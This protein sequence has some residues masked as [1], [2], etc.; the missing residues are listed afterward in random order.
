MNKDRA[1]ESMKAFYGDD[2]DRI[3]HTLRVLDFTERICEGEGVTDPFQRE[4]I[5]M[6]AIF[7]DV[8]IP[9]ALRK[10]GT[11]A[12]PFQEREG[13]PVARRLLIEIGTRPDV[14]ERVCHI[15]GHHHTREAVDGLDFQ[16]FWESDALVNIPRDLAR[17][18]AKGQA[19]AELP[20]EKRRELIDTYFTTATG[21][22]LIMG[23]I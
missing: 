9:V 12:G 7:H 17:Q 3:D 23:L 21:T 15:I 4:V 10:H 5:V 18:R 20:P 11:A 8:G 6:A 1:L 19:P 16:I 13:E 14:L 22:R 2:A